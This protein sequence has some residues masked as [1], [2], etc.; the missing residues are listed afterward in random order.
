M[1]RK[2]TTLFFILITA[3]LFGQVPT[4]GLVG[5]YPFTGNANDMS[6]NGYNGTNHYATLQ[7]IGIMLLAQRIIL[8]ALLVILVYPTLHFFCRIIHFRF[9]PIQL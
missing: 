9:G 1:K 3:A 4:N 6:G 2:L 7:L 8:M 5:Y